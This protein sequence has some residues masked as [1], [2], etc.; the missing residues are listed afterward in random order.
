MVTTIKEETKT[1]D[2]LKSIK[3]TVRIESLGIVS[4]TCGAVSKNKW[5]GNRRC[6]GCGNLADTEVK[7]LNKKG[8]V[9][10]N[11]LL[12]VISKDDRSFHIEKQEI[13]ANIDQ[14]TFELE[15]TYGRKFELIWSLKDTKLVLKREGK[16]VEDKFSVFFRG[17][18]HEEVLNL[19]STEGNRKLLKL[20]YEKLGKIG[21]ERTNKLDRALYRLFQYPKLELFNFAGFGKQLEDIWDNRYSWL[22]TDKTK[23]HQ[24]LGVPKY[25]L[26]YLKKLDRFDGWTLSKWRKMDDKFGGNNVKM[27]L[28]TMDDESDINRFYYLTDHI[29]SLYDNYGY[30][31]HKKLFT[32]LTR[33]IKL[34]QGIADPVDGARTLA[35]YNRM[36]KSMGINVDK[37]SKSL[38]KDHDIAMMNFR[39]MTDE[40]KQENF[41]KE[42]EKPIWDDILYENKEFAIVKPTDPQDLIDEG[43]SLGHCVASYVD[44]VIKGNCK[45]LFL[46]LANMKDEGLI[47]VEVRGSERDKLRIVQVRGRGNR[48]PIPKERDFVREWAEKKNLRV[49]Y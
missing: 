44:D 17:T 32:Y 48:D 4:C 5:Y 15:L 9:R 11:A 49:D 8:R 2:K 6:D 3:E 12:N 36:C 7:S 26:P 45:V 38:K 19:I 29:I 24:I 20:A 34:M 21:G 13:F 31:N 42:M 47:T 46:R 18:T 35:D 30:R 28:E 14:D 1:V 41:K 22:E 16:E 25:M 43:E 37:Y 33:D 39:M 27:M 23:P 10:V 40:K